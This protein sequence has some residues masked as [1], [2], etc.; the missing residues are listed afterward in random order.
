[1]SFKKDANG[2]IVF[3]T[4]PRTGEESI[5]SSHNFCDK[6][7]WYEQSTRIISQ[8]LTT[9]GSANKIFNSPT[10]SHVNWIDLEHGKVHN[11]DDFKDAYKV[12]VRV[13]GVEKTQRI[14][15]EDSSG[16]FKVL[17]YVSGAIE[18]FEA[19]TGSVEADFSIAN[20][21]AWTFSLPAGYQCHIED[22]EGQFSED[23]IL[24]DS[25]IFQ[26]HGYVDVFAPQLLTTNGGPYPPGTKIPIKSS[27]F[28]SLSQV[29]DEAKG[30]YPVIPALGGPRGLL[31]PIYGLPFRYGTIRTLRD[32]Y[33]MEM[34]IFLENDRACEG[35]R[36]TVT[37]FSTLEE[38]IV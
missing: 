15:D 29:I 36:I 22:A 34:K 7:T 20:G 4:V 18:F 24:N 5:R 25:I 28:K 23:S 33:G 27:S 6:T 1:M 21:S 35:S 2:N 37:F 30:S 16:D 14:W 19:V 13:D 10:A 11:E 26:V 3:T 32:S 38:E 31:S 9:S 8:S 17:D 12:N